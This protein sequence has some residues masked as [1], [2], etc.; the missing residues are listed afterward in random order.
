MYYV[1]KRRKLER[2]NNRVRLKDIAGATGFS[3]NT[4]S[5]AL[6]DS[7][8]ISKPTKALIRE[9]AREVGYIGDSIAGA[10]RSGVTKT[11]AIILGDISNPH[12][13]IMIKEIEHRVRKDGYSTFILNTEEDPK[14]EYDAIISTL[15]KNVDGIIICPSQRNDENITFLKKTDVPFV[16]IGRRF[17]DIETDYVICDDRQG[18][19]QITEYLLKLGHRCIA[20]FGGPEYVSSTRER[21]RGYQEALFV[22]N[23]LFD[24][25]MVFELPLLMAEQNVDIYE[26]ISAVNCT[27]VFAFSDLIAWEII[28]KLQEHGKQVPEDYSVVGFDNIQSK[29]SFPF[30]LTSVRSSKSKMSIT[31]A[32]ILLEKMGNKNQETIEEKF[33]QIVIPTDLV[34]RGSCRKL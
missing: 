26:K 3:V 30:P 17:P 33:H 4:I 23:V 15:N 34:I 24:P 18:G 21:L 1:L 12:F 28:T 13:S 6:K 16:L 7:P 5:K 20:F 27:A 10:L 9:K 31:A 32:E 14:L 22:H 11:I 8:S 2:L 29:F 19:F 25:S